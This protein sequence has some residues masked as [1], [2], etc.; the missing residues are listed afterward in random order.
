MISL[1][2]LQ[3]NSLLSIPERVLSLDLRSL[4]AFRIGLGL[5]TAGDI[6]HRLVD[7]RALY[8]DAGAFPRS[9]VT[10]EFS[11]PWFLSLHLVSD[12]LWWQLLLFGL[13]AI[14]GAAL[15]M[16]YRTWLAT[17][18]CW[19]LTISIQNRNEVVLDGGDMVQRVLLFWSLFLPLGAIWS[20]DA[21]RRGEQ[22]VKS[23]TYGVATAALTIQVTSIF[24]FAALLK[25]GDAW[26]KDFKAVW[27]VLNWDVYSTT[28]GV[29]M[30]QFHDVLRGMTIGTMILEGVFPLL[31]FV[32]WAPLR[33]FALASLILFHAS[34]IVVMKLFMFASIMILAWFSLMPGLFWDRLRVPL[35]MPPAWRSRLERLSDWLPEGSLS[36]PLTRRPNAFTTV[37]AI[38][39]AYICCWNVRTVWPA[40]ARVF[41]TA[42]N[43]IGYTLRIDQYWIMFAPSP[44]REDGWFVVPGKV[45]G[46]RMVDVFRGG[47]PLRWERP[48]LVADSYINRRW[49]RFLWNVT[50]ADAP[51]YRKYFAAYLCREW[52][53]KHEELLESFD[54]IL[55]REI[56]QP[57]Y[58]VTTPDKLVLWQNERCR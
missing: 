45:V 11:H 57:D 14:S 17:L 28:V 26:R 8:S 9:A 47:A 29:W 55:M 13:C 56:A 19:V 22:A 34:F 3:F 54:I 31:I 37:A 20:V 46:G 5:F 25:T 24:F 40:F 21:V 2:A 18:I 10:G 36:D 38:C 51:G 41:P 48:K 27:Y 33:I 16:G 35:E 30:R 52:D 32:P 44:V 43:P 23:W 42:L 7:I 49:R 53:R 58:S 39:L 12:A 15:A 4:A 1:P 6:L 50:R